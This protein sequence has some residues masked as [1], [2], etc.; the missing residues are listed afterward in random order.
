M[1]PLQVHEYN[2]LQEELLL[3]KCAT[4]SAAGYTM[5]DMAQIE[6]GRAV[7]P[8]RGEHL[9]PALQMTPPTRDTD[10]YVMDVLRLPKRHERC[11]L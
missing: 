3:F 2:R 7:R 1:D 9:P 11:D 6:P 8:S 10:A 5:A 4:G